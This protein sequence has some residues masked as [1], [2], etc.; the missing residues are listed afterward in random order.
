MG[1]EGRRARHPL[2]AAE[3]IAVLPK[4]MLSRRER[5]KAQ[6]T[7]GRKI[8]NLIFEHIKLRNILNLIMLDRHIGRELR[9]FWF[10]DGIHQIR[11]GTQN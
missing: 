2:W 6:K 4:E 9:E 11:L 10:G 1:Q 8:M 5:V 7:V 3:W